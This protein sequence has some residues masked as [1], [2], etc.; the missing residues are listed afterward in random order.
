MNLFL[1]HG[2]TVMVN[3]YS[4]TFME[5]DFCFCTSSNHAQDFWG[6]AMMRSSR[7]DVFYEKSAL[8]TFVKFTGKRLCRSLIFNEITG[9]RLAIFKKTLQNSCFTGT[10]AKVYTL[11]RMGLFGAARGCGGQKAPLLL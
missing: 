9:L 6:V 10:F 4:T 7:P 8:K 3:R 5:F 1:L 11:F 2:G